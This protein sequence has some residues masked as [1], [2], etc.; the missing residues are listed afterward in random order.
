MTDQTNVHNLPVSATSPGRSSQPSKVGEVVPILSRCFALVRPVGMKDDQAREWL[1]VA[2][3]ELA[4]LPRR[5]LESAAAEARKTC[6]H[7]GQIVPAILNSSAAKYDRQFSSLDWD[8]PERLAQLEAP[9]WKPEPG[10]LDRIKAETAAAL[11]A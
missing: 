5:V 1:T 11:K 9:R 3:A 4:H 6:T 7:H 8:R 10:E 2:A